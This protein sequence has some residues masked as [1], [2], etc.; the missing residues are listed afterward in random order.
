M[1]A[2]LTFAQESTQSGLE[3]F[4]K[5][6]QALGGAAKIAAIRDYEELAFGSVFNNSGRLMGQVR[7]RTRWI[8]PNHL[9]LDP[10]APDATYVLYFDS[11]SG[12]EIPPDTERR[13]SITTGKRSISSA[14]NC[15]SQRTIS[16]DSC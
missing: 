2:G 14:M 11:T 15:D 3:L 5:M 13:A 9:R 10:T 7:K 8:K 1:I 12:W 16:R 6:Q 4:H